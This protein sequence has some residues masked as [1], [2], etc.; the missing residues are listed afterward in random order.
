MVGVAGGV[1]MFSIIVMLVVTLHPPGVVT[2]T[3][4]KSPPFIAL[5]EFKVGENVPDVESW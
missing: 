4:I 5:G 3:V 2:I 1:M